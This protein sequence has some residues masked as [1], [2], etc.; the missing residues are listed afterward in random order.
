MVVTVVVGGKNIEN[1]KKI[2][3]YIFSIFL[4]FIT[5]VNAVEDLEAGKAYQINVNFF[6]VPQ[7]EQWMVDR[8]S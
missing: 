4:L 8:L 5:N 7:N 1:M 3:I 2:Y 6:E